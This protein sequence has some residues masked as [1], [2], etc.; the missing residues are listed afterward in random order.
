MS[1][2]VLLRWIDEDRD[3]LIGF[4]GRFV[5]APSPNPP[6]DTRAATSVIANYLEE[7]GLD[8]EIVEPLANAPNVVASFV[9]ARP[10]RHLVFNGHI[11]V[12]PCDDADRWTHPPWS[13]ELA[14]G[15][16]F[17]RGSSDMK[18]GTASLLFVY[19]Y[20]HRLR[21]ELAGRLTFT[22]VSDEETGG[23]WGAQYLVDQRPVQGDCLL[24]AEPGAPTTIRFGE[25][26][27][28]R[29]RFT[30]R[31]SGCHGAYTHKSK[32]ATKIAAALIGDLEAIAELPVPMASNIAASL[33]EAADEIDR[34]HVRGAAKVIREYTVNIGVVRGGI[35]TNM[36][37]GVCS[38][39]VDI[40]V[41]VGA[42]N[43]AARSK[44][45]EILA[46]YPEVSVETIN[47]SEP[48]WSDPDHEMV[49]CLRN[50]CERVSG[51]A[52][53]TITSLGATDARKWRAKGIPSFTYGT[54]ATNVAMADEHTVIEEWLNVVKVHALAAYDYLRAG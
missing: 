6:G 47:E 48:S 52:P 39:D 28:L 18:N 5:R 4:L 38:L 2:E 17:G 27:A 16:L 9:A 45:M 54:T 32:S 46:G 53:F 26:G 1:K 10:G 51:A 33:S 31:T 30:V 34:I 50:G 41:P 7:Q 25:K 11:D 8:Y 36:L 42:T 15:K 20:L 12:Y 37:P 24:N 49:H 23:T 13:G 29:L 19:A 21:D 40:R 22:A 14:E 43:D 35:K 44:V 3:K